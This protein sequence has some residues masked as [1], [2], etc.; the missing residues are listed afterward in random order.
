MTLLTNLGVTEIL[1]SFTLVLEGKKGKGVIKIRVPRKFFSQQYCF[2]RCRIRGLLAVEYR[3]YSRFTFVDNTIH[4]K[5]RE[6][7]FWEVILFCF[8]SIWK[9]GSFKSPFAMI[10]NLFEL[11]F[12]IL[13]LKTKTVNSMNY[14]SS[15]SS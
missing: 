8:V 2:I 3:K 1:C 5:S 9:F 15:T 4:Q 7:S 14:G 12:T 13:L 11:Y 6:P 10:S